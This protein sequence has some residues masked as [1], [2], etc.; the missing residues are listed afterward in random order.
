MR[1]TKSVRIILKLDFEKAYDKNKLDFLRRGVT[2]E[3]LLQKMDGGLTK[4]FR[5]V[6][7]AL[8]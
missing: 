8:I 7:F 4:Q 6:V 5:E 3:R 2:K 1:T